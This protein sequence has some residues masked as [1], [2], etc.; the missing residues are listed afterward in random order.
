MSFWRRALASPVVEQGWALTKFGC[1]LHCVHEY[2]VEVTMCVGPSMLPT[3]NTA[4]DVVILDRASRWLKWHDG[5]GRADDTS[6]PAYSAGCVVIARSPTNP[7][8]TVCKRVVAVAGDAVFLPPSPWEQ[9]AADSDSAAA[10]TT[11]RSRGRR[12]RV[13]AGHVW[14]EGDNPHN[15]TDSRQYGPVPEALVKGRVLCK[16]WPPWELGPVRPRPCA[17]PSIP[18]AGVHKPKKPATPA[19]G[20]GIGAAHAATPSP[21]PSSTQP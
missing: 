2:V 8:Q 4:G 5:S 13:P 11:A 17:S 18:V 16:V 12:V 6:A 10:P 20:G 3:F 9:L 7:D 19:A 15:S 1:F 21:M 14:L